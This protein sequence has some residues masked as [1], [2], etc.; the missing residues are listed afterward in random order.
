MERD[1]VPAGGGSSLP[2]PGVSGI[3]PAGTMTGTRGASLE[4][5]DETRR[6]PPRS[7]RSLAR[8]EP[9]GWK[10]PW[11]RTVV[12]RRWASAPG[13]ARAAPAGAASLPRPS[14][15]R[16]PLLLSLH[17]WLKSSDRNDAGSHR[18][19]HLTK[20]GAGSGRRFVAFHCGRDDNSGAGCIPRTRLFVIARSACDEAIQEPPALS[21]GLL[22]YARNDGKASAPAIAGEGDHAKHGGGGAGGGGNSDASGQ[23]S[24]PAPRP[25]RKCAVPPPRYRGAG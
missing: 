22:R 2:L 15:F 14:A 7:A 19:R 23:A 11:V 3:M 5:R 8:G 18:R 1:A 25:P 10:V 4:V 6:N 16:L 21:A 9:L 24:R 12:E 13:K 20:I 17:S